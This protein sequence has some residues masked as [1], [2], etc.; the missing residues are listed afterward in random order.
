MISA[1]QK[2]QKAPWNRAASTLA[3]RGSVAS[4]LSSF[5][6]PPGLTRSFRLMT[7]GNARR[8][9]RNFTQ[10]HL[11]DG[12]RSGRPTD[13]NQLL[14]LELLFSTVAK[15]RA[16]ISRGEGF[17]RDQGTSLNKTRALYN[18]VSLTFNSTNSTK[19]GRTI[20]EI[21]V[22]NFG[23]VVPVINNPRR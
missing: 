22:I 21:R 12:S 14:L 4:H 1:V 5:E 11:R 9:A 13:A 20:Y 8:N 6:A 18:H 16:A 10:T 19:R 2:A 17:N 3:S 7:L 15:I 23:R